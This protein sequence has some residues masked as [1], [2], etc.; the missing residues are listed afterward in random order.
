MV[1]RLIFPLL[2]AA[3]VLASCA[4]FSEEEC[5]YSDWEL[6]GQNDGANGSS[7]GAFQRYVKECGRYGIRPDSVAYE[8][9][10]KEGLKTYCTPQGV[11][12]AGMRGRGSAAVCG[13]A[14][15]L[16]RIHRITIE[17]FNA[18]R[19]V[20][21]A[22]NEYERLFNRRRFV[23]REIE[24]IRDKLAYDDGLSDEKRKNFRR[25]LEDY[26]DE[27]DD[28]DRREYRVRFFLRDRERDL[29]R[30][31]AALFMLQEELG[32]RD[33]RPRY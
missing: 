6:V 11:Y 9:G 18:R 13:N 31:E 3:A 12:E 14:P 21:R 20:A 23:R 25:Q 2:M 19:D 29:A 5:Q 30:A 10:R 27:L 7:S 16:A 32:L 8:R 4:T 1:F 28:F 15:E 17:Y 24:E 33:Y 22:R 26:Y